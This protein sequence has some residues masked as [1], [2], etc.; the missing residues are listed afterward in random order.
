MVMSKFS[1]NRTIKV[2]AITA[3]ALLI[4]LNSATATGFG[5]TTRVSLDSSGNQA[6]SN[7]PVGSEN[8]AISADGRYVVFISRVSSLA[9][10]DS[11]FSVFA[12]VYV[13]DRQTH[14]TSRVS[15]DTNGKRAFIAP[16][17]APTISAD[18]RVAAYSAYF[19]EIAGCPKGSLSGQVVVHD[20]QTGQ[21]DCIS[22]DATGN[23][24]NG[25]SSTLSISADGR[26]VAFESGASNLVP[27]DT[28]H[29]TDV[30]VRDRQ[31]G[32]TTRVSVD[33]E[34][35]QATPPNNVASGSSHPSIS[36]DGRYVAFESF[37]SNMVPEDTNDSSDIFVHDR[38][39]G[40]TSLVSASSDGVLGN[41]QSGHPSISADGRYVAFDS[42]TD[43]V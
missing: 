14:A 2:T 17:T 28:N 32:I 16:S 8:P 26:Y 29:V 9:G 34:G 11:S 13:H 39:T 4:S 31:T 33:S 12:D 19:S 30:F 5:T 37:A 23:P 21:N 20:L 27:N 24:A 40:T 1:L 7:F 15:D 38:Q 6:A 42:A 35:N 25:G 43:N 10:T 3:L 36:A 18:G 22:L 41:G